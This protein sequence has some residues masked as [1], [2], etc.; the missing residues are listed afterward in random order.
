MEHE[1]GCNCED[2]WWMHDC[3]VVDEE[4]MPVEQEE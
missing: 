4:G 2:C 3:K 1:I